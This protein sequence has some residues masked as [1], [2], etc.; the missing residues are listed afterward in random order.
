MDSMTTSTASDIAAI[1]QIEARLHDLG[2]QLPPPRERMGNFLGAVRTGDLLF[3]SGQGTDRY[4]GKVGRDLDLDDAYAAARDCAL[5]LLGLVKAEL[6]GLDRVCR[7]VKLLGFVNCVEG[8]E[9][10]PLVVNGASDLLVE[11]YGEAGRHARTAVGV[12]ALPRNFAVEIEMV[13]QVSDR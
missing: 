11:L 6:G 2:L 7:V 4:Q 3:L 8:Y 10:T 9:Q 13:V 5:Y 1:D 12:A